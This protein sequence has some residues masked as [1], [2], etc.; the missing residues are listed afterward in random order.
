[1]QVTQQVEIDVPAEQAWE[2]LAD[3][4]ADVATWASPV[5]VSDATGG[6]RACA[7]AVP[8]ASRMLEQLLAVDHDARTLSHDAVGMP[9][10]V[11]TARNDWRVE[12]VGDRRCRVTSTV[13]LALAPAGTPLA[14][15]AGVGVR[16]LGRRV[17]ADLR[18][19]LEH[20][21]VSPAKQ[22]RLDRAG[23][24]GHGDVRP[25][26][27][28]VR[29]NASFSA[30]CALVLLVVAG[31]LAAPLGID[32]TVLRT[33]GAGLAVGVAAIPWVLARPHRVV[34]ACPVVV[35]SDAAWVLGTAVVLAWPG[36]GITPL[37]RGVL[38]AVALVVAGVG[39]AQARG[40]R[41]ARRTRDAADA[42]RPARV[43][44][45]GDRDTA[46]A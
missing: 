28:A 36:L 24:A 26:V 8:G 21:E 20:G 46:G 15:L 42:A 35:A 10:P 12:V 45:V 29:S 27:S 40:L 22:R 11:R 4:F 7:T 23:A 34:V 17:L 25:L 9:W 33:V 13:T 1:M 14:P 18:H 30:V 32:A 43:P 41:H 38:V 44:T 31:P 3:G 16:V 37:G 5:D 2:L 19:V 6:G 39:I